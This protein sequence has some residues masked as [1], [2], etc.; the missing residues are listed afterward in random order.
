VTYKIWVGDSV[1]T[2]EERLKLLDMSLVEIGGGAIP[3]ADG[4]TGNA[5]GK[6]RYVVPGDPDYAEVQAGCRQDVLN[7]IAETQKQL[8]KARAR[9]NAAAQ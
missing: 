6:N 1:G 7:A 3:L 2:L 5:A 9:E 8:V 4:P